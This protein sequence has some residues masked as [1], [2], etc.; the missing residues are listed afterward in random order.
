M[1]VAVAM[2]GGVDSSVAAAVLKERGYDVTGVTMRLTGDDW[3]ASAI[4][5]AR[6]AADRLGIRHHVV[7]FSDVFGQEVIADFC[8]EYSLGRT[9]NPCIR[10][11]RY[12][13]FGA[14]LERAAE[15]GC[16]FIATG[17][18]ARVVSDGVG[19][20]LKRGVDRRKDQSYFLYTLNQSQLGR[21]LLPVGDLTKQRVREMAAGLGLDAAGVPESREI[22]FIPDKDYAGFLKH[23]IP[24]AAV[25]GPVLDRAGTVLGEHRGILFYT[26][27]QRKRLGVPAG[28]PLYVTAI[29]PERNA[30]IVGGSHDVYN[31]QLVASRLNW[32]AGSRPKYPLSVTAS[33][34]YLH[35]AAEAV[36]VPLG[37]D[38]V[39]VSFSQPQMAVTPGQAV[40]FYQGDVVLGGGTIEGVEEDKR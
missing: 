33:I 16:D 40:V 23:R 13:K 2:S 24:R 1:K 26:I 30:I 10:C 9:P 34:R 22:C 15:L 19:Y 27:G 32:I 12:I 18:Y 6:K 5:D 8:H 7:D 17:H 39:R 35:P 3:G 28:E 11:N 20:R 38:R 37:S 31:S 25:P 21:V 4:D 14:L 36:V 29:D